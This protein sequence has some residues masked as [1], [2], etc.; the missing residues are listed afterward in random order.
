MLFS[1][2]EDCRNTQKPLYSCNQYINVC[3]YFMLHFRFY[4]DF[5]K[6]LYSIFY[7]MH[8]PQLTRSVRSPENCRAKVLYVNG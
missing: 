1:H 5:M 8:N 7:H 6:T 4:V 2:A 3:C